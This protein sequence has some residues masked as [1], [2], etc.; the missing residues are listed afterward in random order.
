M[1]STRSRSRS[2]RRRERH[3]IALIAAALAALA[4]TAQAPARQSS[5]PGVQTTGDVN[6]RTFCGRQF[7]NGARNSLF[8]ATIELQG[9]RK[10]GTF[11]G[12]ALGRNERRALSA[13]EMPGEYTRERLAGRVSSSPAS[14]VVAAAGPRRCRRPS[15]GGS[16][17]EAVAAGQRP[18][19]EAEGGDLR[20]GGTKPARHH[21]AVTP[22]FSLPSA[23]R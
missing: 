8:D 16:P 22:S 19:T 7:P 6:Y 23:S 9:G 13:A 5:T 1:C 11:S 15:P 2:P 12:P 14:S 20:P 4:L 17:T 21:G 18:G 10:R 3:E